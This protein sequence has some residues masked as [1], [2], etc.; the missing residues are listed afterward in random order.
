MWCLHRTYTTLQLTLW[1]YTCPIAQRRFLPSFLLHLITS[2]THQALWPAVPKT[3]LQTQLL[4]SCNTDYSTVFINTRNRISSVY[5]GLFRDWRGEEQRLF[6]TDVRFFK[7][8][9][10]ALGWIKGKKKHRP[11]LWRDYCL[12]PMESWA[13]NE[14]WMENEEWDK[15]LYLLHH[16][17]TFVSCLPT[18]KLA[19]FFFF[20]VK[21]VF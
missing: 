12:F 21:W 14:I 8:F 3:I 18:S 9:Q 7:H 6:C 10:Y 11:L 19:L 1:M 15:G 2:I 20:R 17:L 5:A 4:I 13:R 16:P